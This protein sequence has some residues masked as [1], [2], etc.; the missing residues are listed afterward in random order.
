[1][2]IYGGIEGGGTKFVCAVGRG[3]ADV[4]ATTTFD[5]T[6]PDVTIARAIAFFREHEQRGGPLSG[7]GVAMFGPVDLRLASPTYGRVLGT[8]KPGWSGTDIVGPLQAAFPAIPV[9]LDTD[10]DAAALAE[11]RW[12]A[13]TGCDPALYLTVG[14]GIG[15]G[16]VVGGRPLHGLLHPEMGHVPVR[17]HPGEPAAFLGVC[18]FHGDCLEG[19]ASGPAIERR[20][21][22]SPETLPAD[23][24]AWDLEAH[25]LA[26]ALSGYIYTLAPQ[27]IVLSGGV[28]QRAGLLAGVRKQVRIMLGGYV[29]SQMVGDKIEEYIVAP[30]LG[31]RAGVLGAVAL[32][33]SAS[34]STTT[35]PTLSPASDS[36]G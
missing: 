27:R 36:V 16:V 13:A 15:G 32:A 2:A 24:P 34:E 14:T 35:P 17:R 21:G 19:M 4:R 12:G 33:L 30:G 28:M 23:H 1:M 31:D 11:W 29:R 25:Y 5:T 20:W 10:V 18:P 3:P 7:L 8:P 26:Q 9:S 22:A 6:T